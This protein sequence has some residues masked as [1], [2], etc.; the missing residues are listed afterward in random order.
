[1]SHAASA[2]SPPLLQKATQAV[3]VPD[4]LTRCGT[5]HPLPGSGSLPGGP[6]VSAGTLP[7]AP[8]A[9]PSLMCLA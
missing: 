2:W 6:D 4:R 9:H 7:T 8:N 5:D 1:M 3:S